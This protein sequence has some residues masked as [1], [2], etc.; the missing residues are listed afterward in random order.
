MA[1]ENLAQA[2]RTKE[3]YNEALRNRLDEKK[4]FKYMMYTKDII[5]DSERDGFSRLMDGANMDDES[6][7][8]RNM[9]AGAGNTLATP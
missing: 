8:S 2:P 9:E 5:P 7:F 1:Y 6:E 3:Y 4:V